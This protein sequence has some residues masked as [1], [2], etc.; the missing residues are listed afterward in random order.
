MAN[1][2]IIGGGIGGLTLANALKKADPKITFK[3]FERDQDIQSRK[4]GYALGLNG[5]GGLLALKRLGL[6]EQIQKLARPATDFSF[7]TSSGKRLMT[8]R[9]VPGTQYYT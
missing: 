7:L 5:A 9:P 3:V 6:Y 4:Q 2:A 1:V 8:F